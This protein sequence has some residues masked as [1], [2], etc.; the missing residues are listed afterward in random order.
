MSRKFTIPITCAAVLFFPL[1]L[2]AESEGE[3]RPPRDRQGSLIER[4]DKDGDGRISSSEFDGPAEHFA[5]LDK[6][7]DGFISGEEAIRRPGRRGSREE[8]GGEQRR[9]PSA[10]SQQ[11]ERATP[12][13]PDSDYSRSSE[14]RSERGGNAARSDRPAGGFVARLDKDSDGRVSVSEFDGPAEHFQHMDKNGDGFL[15]AEEAPTGPPPRQQGER[16]GPPE[17]K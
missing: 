2:M 9:D 16:R 14:P 10:E 17:R 13:R 1:A 12:R 5:H 11:T 8:R 7:G 6:N 15:S 3:G 4:L